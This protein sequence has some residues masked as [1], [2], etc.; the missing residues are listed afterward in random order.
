LKETESVQAS[1]LFP[2]KIVRKIVDY[3][4][5]SAP[6]LRL[7][8]RSMKSCVDECCLERPTVPLG[9]DLS[10]LL[11]C[12]GEPCCANQLSV[13]ARVP[14]RKANLFELRLKAR[15]DSQNYLKGIHRVPTTEGAFVEYRLQLDAQADNSGVLDYLG[16]AVGREIREVALLDCHDQATLSFLSA[17]PEWLEI[18]QLRVTVDMLSDDVV[19]HLLSAVR[20]HSVDC[21][22]LWISQST[23]SHEVNFL[24]RLSSL[25]RC[26]HIE[27]TEIEGIGRHDQYFCGVEHYDWTPTILDMFERKLDKLY[28]RNLA[29]ARYLSHNGCEAIRKHLPAL[30]KKVWFCATCNP[31]VICNYKEHDHHVFVSDTYLKVKHSSRLCEACDFH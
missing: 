25:V 31:P 10:I 14:A 7:T 19:D 8:S 24:L 26:I 30:G 18:E 21:F 11:C 22:G 12:Q 3:S 2:R 9:I 13:T 1:D 6:E 4:P 15:P 23:A 27:Q 5:E 28:I 17:L 29:S 20:K 16:E